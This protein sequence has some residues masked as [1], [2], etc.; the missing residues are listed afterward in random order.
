MATKT[1]RCQLLRTRRNSRL[2]NLREALIELITKNL[3]RRQ[4]PSI[5]R[6][7]ILAKDSVLHALYDSLPNAA[8]IG[9][10]RA[11]YVA[12]RHIPHASLHTL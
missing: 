8:T 11:M 6:A 1:L 12:Q 10:A 3:K 9:S 7:V 5:I 2:L 4:G